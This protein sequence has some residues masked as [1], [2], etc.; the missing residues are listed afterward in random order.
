MFRL[1]LLFALLASL[2][3]PAAASAAPGSVTLVRTAGTAGGAAEQAFLRGRMWRVTGRRPGTRGRGRA[4]PP[5]R[6]T[7]LRPR[8]PRTPSGSSR[9]SGA[10]ACTSARRTPPTSA[11]RSYRAWWI[12]QATAQAAASAASTST[13]SR[14]SGA[15]VLVGLNRDAARS[16]HEHD[17][18]RGDLAALH[19]RLH[20]RG[21]RRAA[22]RRDRRTTWSGRRAPAR[23]DLQ[24]TARRR[25]PRRARARLQRPVVVAGTG[26]NGWQ[27]LAAFVEAQ[28]GRRARRDPRQL[29]DSVAGIALRAR[30]LPADGSGGAAL[31]NDA[32]TAPGSFWGGYDVRLGAPR[33]GRWPWNGVWRRD[34]A[35]GIVLVNEPGA[36]ERTLSVGPGYVDL[37]GTPASTSVTLPAA[38]RRARARCRSQPPPP[39]P[40]PAPVTEAPPAT[41]ATT[42]PPMPHDDARSARATV[43]TR[44]AGARGP[45]TTRTSAALSALRVYGRVRGAIGGE[46]RVTVQRRRGS[47]WTTVRRTSATVTRRGAYERSIARLARGTYRVAARFLG[48]GTARPS[49]SELRQPLASRLA[50]VARIALV[51]EPPDGGVAEHVAQLAAGL[52]AHGH[53]PVV[54]DSPPAAVPARLRPPAPGRAG[55]GRAGAARCAASTS[56]TRTRPRPA[57]WGGSPRARAGCPRSTR[58]TASR[59]S[60]RSRARAGRSRSPSSARWRAARRR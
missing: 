52:P 12:A 3:A 47:G 60:A 2:L 21:A 9:T 13:T 24:P 54:F 44:G 10:T 28:P 23:S 1:I 4:R 8:P 33:G 43:T 5:T 25:R 42:E 37:D 14:W 16:A 6:S 58:R 20:G 41:A 30:E 7:R 45:R 49:S 18:E 55:A 53:E 35:N 56:C 51:C 29:T 26:R 59:S 22:E 50:R 27:T 46:V 38:R 39:P 34:F 11:T 17:H 15:C 40:P 19:G 36:A 57:W 32:A 31:G 48:T